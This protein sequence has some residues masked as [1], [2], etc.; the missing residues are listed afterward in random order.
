MEN[1]NSGV[2]R[3]VLGGLHWFWC[4]LFGW[5]YYATKGAWG[6][7]FLSLF[8]L[9]GLFIIM[10]ICNRSIIRNHYENNGWVGLTDD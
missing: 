7:T 8:T 6:M 3:K 10:P 1:I 5:V 2:E 9:N 4:F